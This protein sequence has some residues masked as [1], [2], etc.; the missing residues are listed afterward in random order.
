LAVKRAQGLR[1]G[2]PPTLDPATD[3]RICAARKRGDTV[4][5]IA[6][7]LNAD[8]VPTAHGG[9]RWHPATV[10]AVLRRHGVA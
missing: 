4:A 1:L 10:R 6:E 8:G 7:R 2:R 3:R 5:A 9:A